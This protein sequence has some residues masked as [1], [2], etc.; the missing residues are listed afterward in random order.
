MSVLVTGAYGRVGMSLIEHNS[1]EFE[2]T[3]FDRQDHSIKETIVGDV[4]N[5][6]AVYDAIKGND[7]VVHLAAEPQVDAMWGSVLENNIIGSYNCIKA[8]RESQVE[9][10]VLASTN[11][12]VGMY[13]QEHAPE[14]YK[15]KYD[16]LLDHHSPPRPDSYYASSKLFM[17]GL[18]RYYVENYEFPKQ[19]YALRFGSIRCPEYDHPF[20]DAERGVENGDWIRG[21]KEYQW[22]VRRMKATWQSRRD[23]AQL[24]ECCLK[25]SSVEFDVFYGV[26]DNDRRWFDLERARAILGYHPEDN[27][28]NWES[29]PSKSKIE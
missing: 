29:P 11:H 16:L 7:S 12:V 18:G 19:V 28:E 17:E 4:S 9:S 21:S 24:I 20:G 27:G 26:S 22:S 15:K 8:C 6:E 23:A 13:E 14:L 3:S 10:L 1:G 2:Y 5:Y 25:D